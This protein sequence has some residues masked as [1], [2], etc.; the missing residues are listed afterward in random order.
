MKER[1]SDMLRALS[2][3]FLNGNISG[4]NHPFHA[5][6]HANR[7]NFNLDNGSTFKRHERIG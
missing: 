6:L 4:R 1:M 7:I 5:N 3:A 2:L